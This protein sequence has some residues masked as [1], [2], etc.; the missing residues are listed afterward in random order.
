MSSDFYTNL[1]V[2]YAKIIFKICRAYSHSE[3]DFEDLYQ[4]VCL[5][6]WRTK[7]NFCGD[8][9][10]STWVY[11]ISV[12]VCLTAQK[13]ESRRRPKTTSLEDHSKVL[14]DDRSYFPDESLAQLYV[15]IRQLPDIEKAIILLYLEE[16]TYKE[17]AEVIGIRAGHAGVKIQRI[18]QRLRKLLM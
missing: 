14:I 5:Q 10:W 11:R 1:I 9:Q 12:N 4:E 16:K 7:D 8:A 18:K 15:A 2:P 3:E 17:I 13:Q 6:I